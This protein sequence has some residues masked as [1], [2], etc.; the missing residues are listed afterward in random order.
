MNLLDTHPAENLDI[1]DQLFMMKPKRPI[2]ITLI[3]MGVMYLV[4]LFFTRLYLTID[5][6]EYLTT[7]SS[8]VSPRYLAITGLI[9]GIVGISIVYGLWFRKR[10]APILTRIT[11]LIYLLYYWFDRL[12]LSKDPLK[13]SSQPFAIGASVVIISAI[14]WTFTRQNSH[15]FFGEIHDREIKN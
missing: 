14:L 7:S 12:F 15:T 11:S 3:M 4:L 10:W 8:V 1:E 9:W 5:Q 2:R 6:W 13:A